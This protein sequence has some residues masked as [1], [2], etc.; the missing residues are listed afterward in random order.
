MY[1]TGFAL[2]IGFVLDLI[3]GDPQGW[4]HPIRLIG[5]LISY[6][7]K[8]IRKI[9]PKTARGEF[10]GGIL[11]V[12]LV[13]GLSTLVPLALVILAGKIHWGLKLALESIMCYYLLATKSL[14]DESMKVHTALM[15]G[16][17]EKSRYAVSMIVGRDTKSLTEEGV[18]KAAVETV[19]ENTSDGILAPMLFMAIGGPVLGFFYKSVNTMDS[20]VGYIEEP[21]THFGTFPAKLDDVLN[22]IPARISAFLMIFA[23]IF[24]GM[25]TKNAWKMYFRD[26]YN[27]ASPNSAHTEA[28]MAGALD[29]Q[30]A[31]DA[32]YF[33]VLH[34]KKT[35][36]DPIRPIEIDDIK[37]ANKLLYGAAIVSIIVFL[38]IR[39]A[40]V[41]FI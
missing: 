23:T 5:N 15:T 8:A 2:L 29:I 41:Y 30:L 17:I 19:A 33:G 31:G 11:L 39:F 22:Y 12:I 9:V 14:K 18:T 10:I 20:M 25:D 24:V 35:I 13:S 40:I 7:E 16:D 32:Y 37:K 34:K 6:G 28:V 38:A 36:G 27:H 3:I 1:I 26:R 4:W 21:Y